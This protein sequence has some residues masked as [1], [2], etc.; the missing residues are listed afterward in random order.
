MIVRSALFLSTALILSQAALADVLP[1][2]KE[3]PAPAMTPGGE[4]DAPLL[5]PDAGPKVEVP[6]MDSTETEPA[7]A[8]DAAATAPTAEEKLV[9]SLVKRGG[10]IVLPGGQAQI[11]VSEEFA[12]LDADDTRRVLVDLWGNPPDN[13]DGVLG[14]I[15]PSEVSLLDQGS[16][17]AIITYENEGHIADDDAKS[18]DYGDLLKEMQSSTADASEERVEKGY[19]PISLVGWAEAPKYDSVG[20]KLYWAKHLQ[21]G[22]D[23]HTLNYAIR[24]LGRTGVL[25]INVVAG[26]DQLDS[27]NKKVPALLNTVSFTDGNKY[28]DFKEGDQVAAYGLAALV[29]GGVAAKAGLFKGLLALLI[30]SWKL[31]AVGVVVIGGLIARW[32]G[33][34]TKAPG[35]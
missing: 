25:Q 7:S 30:A 34:R 10:T 9:A 16:W 22:K 20:H 15:I 8:A 29:A 6:S 11:V 33:S 26:M 14:A 35:A 27:V 21:F 4:A 17:A 5:P 28:T 32:F 18:I 24:A 13:A 12:Y 1:P 3:Q 2:P 31:I 23:A 19:E